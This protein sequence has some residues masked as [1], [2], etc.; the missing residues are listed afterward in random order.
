LRALQALALAIL[1]LELMAAVALASQGEKGAIEW[2]TYKYDMSRT[3][4][5]DTHRLYSVFRYNDFKVLWKVKTQLCVSSSPAIGDLDGD[6]RP[7]VAFS[8]CD[9]HLYIVRGSSGEILWNST[10]GGGFASPTLCDLDGDGLP[11]IVTLGASGTVYTFDG[12]G[13]ELWEVPG[14][15]IRGSPAAADVNRD[16]WPEVLAPSFDGK[17]YVITREGRTLWSIRIGDYPVSTPAVAD[18]DGDGTP[19]AVVTDGSSLVLVT[20]KPGGYEVYHVDLKGSLVGPPALY[21]FT[22]D[23]HPD[24]LVVSQSCIVYVV[25]LVGGDVESARLPGASECYSPP[26]VGDVTGDGRPDIVA[27]SLQGLYILS[28]SL[29]VEYQ[30]PEIR[31][32]TS[33][34]I[35]A[36]VDGDGRNE[37]LVGQES[38][39]FDVIDTSLASEPYGEVQWFLVTGGPIM[40]SAAVADV[41]GDGAPEILVGSRDFNLYC[42][43]GIK[44]T[45]SAS[46]QTVTATTTG[47]PSPTQTVTPSPTRPGLPQG[48]APSGTTIR[49]R[50]VA[51]AVAAAVAIVVLA[52]LYYSRP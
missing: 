20:F 9:G 51:A 25:D 15:F 39:E 34:P 38:G 13:R 28:G 33:S 22:G 47:I 18:V 52:T 4:F 30:F 24:A 1:S 11:E 23:G 6:G 7:E 27:G 49:W 2:P 43:E 37:I 31:V 50:I 3:G 21:D 45:A 32:Y 44:A 19:D 5:F 36:D 12:N 14:T 48:P 46:S 17:L 26:S 41:D 42:I 29:R 8:S 16:G 40:G 10:T 35:I